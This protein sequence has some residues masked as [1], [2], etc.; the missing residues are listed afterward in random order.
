MDDMCEWVMEDLNY[1]TD[2]G[3]QHNPW[4]SFWC[5]PKIETTDSGDVCPYCNR[6]IKYVEE[7]D[8][9]NE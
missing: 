3:K 1:F 8:I 9:N 2:C 6:L 7:E 5:Q 4:V